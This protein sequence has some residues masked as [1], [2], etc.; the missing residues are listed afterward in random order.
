MKTVPLLIAVLTLCPA[1]SSAGTCHHA[2][3]VE[4]QVPPAFAGINTTEVGF[5]TYYWA[6]GA[7]PSDQGGESAEVVDDGA[8][9][10]LNGG[11]LWA[12]N[13]AC[14]GAITAT[15]VLVEAQT[16]SEGGRYAV[17]VVEAEGNVDA[18]QPAGE[19]SIAESLPVPAITGVTTGADAYG[20]YVDFAIAWASP[21]GAAW[22]LA[23][24]TP[25]LAGYAVYYRMETPVNS[26][27]K[28][29]FARIDSTPG[30]TPYITDDPDTADGLLPAT[31]NHCTVRLRAGEDY[32]LATA[33]ILDGSGAMGTDPQ[34]D[35]SAVHTTYVSACSPAASVAD[36]LFADGFETSDTSA[37]SSTAP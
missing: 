30:A 9:L 23:T 27:D 17:L 5:T 20:S 7:N 35:A 37:W 18:I 34:A 21:S 19:Q 14:S 26:G 2:Y 24:V 31:H 13:A 25:V 12:N 15:G 28:S 36:V 29:Q 6:W 33:L 8:G 16:A 3:V 32:F 22:A 11:I 10:A 4:G 1:M